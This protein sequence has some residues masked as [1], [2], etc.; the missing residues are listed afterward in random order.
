MYILCIM[1]GMETN[2]KAT[3]DNH[4]D[5][6]SFNVPRVY[7]CAI[8]K[9]FMSEPMKA[10][11]KGYVTYFVCSDKCY[12]EIMGSSKSPVVLGYN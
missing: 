9:T 3:Q 6:K 7:V 1:E 12:R 2:D 11:V 10:Y 5:E 8:C 4:L